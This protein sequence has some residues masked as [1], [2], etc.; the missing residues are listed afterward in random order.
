MIYF[1]LYIF[2]LLMWDQ[3]QHHVI[4]LR[5]LYYEAA[6]DGDKLE[7]FQ[8]YL[9]QANQLQPGV[10]KGYEAMYLFLISKEL[11]NPVEKWKSFQN[12]KE[13][14]DETIVENNNMAELRFLRM[15]IQHSVPS[16][17]D[18][19]EDLQKD[20]IYLKDKLDG[21]KDLDLKDR[22][23]NFLSEEGYL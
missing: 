17:L 9:E 21:L 22:I 7:E 19:H 14:L 5:D 3:N 18:Y 1:V 15:T 10:K 20:K 23:Y 4:Q 8:T 12:G 16:F 11:W 2:P 13:L 6:E